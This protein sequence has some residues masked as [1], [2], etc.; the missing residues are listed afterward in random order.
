LSKTVKYGTTGIFVVV[1]I[2]KLIDESISI[3]VI[4]IRMFGSVTVNAKG[5]KP[6]RVIK[7]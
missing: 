6:S 3:I 4:P 1:A 5:M 7:T 2:L